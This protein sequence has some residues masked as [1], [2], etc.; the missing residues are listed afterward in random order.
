[1]E[2]PLPRTYRP[3]YLAYIIKTF[4]KYQ[5]AFDK[6]KSYNPTTNPTTRTKGYPQNIISNFNFC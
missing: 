2:R 3:G 4:R 5:A 6:V 1:M